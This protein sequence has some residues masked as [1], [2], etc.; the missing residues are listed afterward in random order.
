MPSPPFHAHVPLILRLGRRPPGVHAH[1]P[2]TH[3]GAS[4]RML[5]VW[6]CAVIPLPY[7]L[8]IERLLVALGSLVHVAALRTEDCLELSLV[9]LRVCV[10]PSWHMDHESSM[11]LNRMWLESVGME[12]ARWV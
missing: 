8:P 3:H 1:K 2:E 12:S 6:T 11:A 4:R 10:V 5:L 7:R 9:V